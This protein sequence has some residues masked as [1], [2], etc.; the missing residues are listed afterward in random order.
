M[1]EI[2]FIFQVENVDKEG[3]LAQVSTALEKRL[4][5]RQQQIKPQ[6]N[7]PDMSNMTEEQKQDYFKRQ[8]K[9]KIFWGIV[10]LA[11][12]IYMVLA[13]I[14]NPAAGVTQ[15][16]VGV[17]AI[18]MGIYY[19]LFGG[20]Q[21]KAKQLKDKSKFVN[22]AAEF[23]DEQVKHTGEKKVQIAFFEEEMVTITGELDELDQDAVAYS[24][25][26]CALEGPDMF[27][28][29]YNN[30]GVLLQKKDLTMGSVEEFRAFLLRSVKNFARLEDDKEQVSEEKTEETPKTEE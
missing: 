23:L 4:E 27:L 13:N 21:K 1:D 2:Q 5:I 26:E 10:I 6:K 28:L 11:L 12:G 30:R 22:A 19:L 17:F 15:L 14:K 25:M 7:M 20:K 24:D 8:R 29:T 18:I 9:Y 3:L 16:V